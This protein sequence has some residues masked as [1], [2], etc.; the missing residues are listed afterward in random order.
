[1]EGATKELMDIFNVFGK[2]VE[3]YKSVVPNLQQILEN[4]GDY[5]KLSPK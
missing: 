3:M 1:M 2:E 5:I 4:S